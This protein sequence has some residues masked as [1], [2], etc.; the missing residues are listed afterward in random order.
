MKRKQA[1]ISSQTAMMKKIYNIYHR[2]GHFSLSHFAHVNLT[3]VVR[4]T[5]DN[6]FIN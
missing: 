6:I 5:E 1:K 2:R 3:I 4:I